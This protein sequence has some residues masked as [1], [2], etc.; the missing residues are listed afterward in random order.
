[1]GDKLYIYSLTKGN[2]G[3]ALPCCIVHTSNIVIFPS[4]LHPSIF[5][6]VF[7]I[8]ENDNYGQVII[9]VQHTEAVKVT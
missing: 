6:F 7:T 3:F 9:K 5:L 1:M 8:S 2:A 4:I